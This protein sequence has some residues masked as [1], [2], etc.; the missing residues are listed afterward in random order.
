MLIDK[1]NLQVRYIILILTNKHNIFFN[2]YKIY[3]FLHKHIYNWLFFN[4]FNF[5]FNRQ[6]IF[7]LCLHF[8]Y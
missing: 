2:L 6:L 8:A 4:I 5:I 7:E 3:I 1:I